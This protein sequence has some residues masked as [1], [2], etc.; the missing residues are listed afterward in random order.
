[1][2]PVLRDRYPVRRSGTAAAWR[3]AP[4]ALF[5]GRRTGAARAGLVDVSRETALEV[6][7]A[8]ADGGGGDVSPKCQMV[9]SPASIASS[10]AASLAPFTPSPPGRRR[11]SGVTM[12]HSAPTFSMRYRRP[13]G[14]LRTWQTSEISAHPFARFRL[15]AVSVP[16]AEPRWREGRRTPSALEG[17]NRGDGR[18]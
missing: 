7:L 1:M 14:H 12:T 15:M 3:T 9:R 5:L 8:P 13:L 4:R 11:P 18:H 6:A 17:D 2:L 10:S 16:R